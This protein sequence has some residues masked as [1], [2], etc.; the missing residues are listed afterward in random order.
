MDI[1]T[2]NFNVNYHCLIQQKYELLSILLL[3]FQNVDAN[4][5]RLRVINCL[6]IVIADSYKNVL[7]F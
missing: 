7:S 4:N 5:S 6:K 1:I 3:Q 2:D